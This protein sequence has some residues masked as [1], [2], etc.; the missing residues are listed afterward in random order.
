MKNKAEPIRF[1]FIE[2]NPKPCSIEELN[3]H[4]RAF[5]E[6]FIE[7]NY[8]NRWMHIIF[9]KPDKA[10]N[11]LSKLG[12]SISKK[13]F[14]T[15]I[16]SESFPFS[17]TNKFGNKEGIFFD[18]IESPCKL[19]AGEAASLKEERDV[20]ALFSMIPG[21]LALFFFHGGD[22]LLCEKK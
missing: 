19:T 20:D 14:S 6:E 3:I 21:K 18:G 10:K 4:L 7:P 16:G 9:E 5:G 15:L 17:L 13:F 8:L 22:V 12:N 1:E 2:V 11:E